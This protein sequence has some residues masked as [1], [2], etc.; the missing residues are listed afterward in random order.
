MKH[1]KTYESHTA[2][3]P[4]LAFSK[5]DSVETQTEHYVNDATYSDLDDD[6]VETPIDTELAILH[7]QEFIDDI[8]DY[9]NADS[10]YNIDINLQDFREIYNEM[11]VKA[12]KAIFD[13]TGYDYDKN[14]NEVF[15]YIKNIGNYNL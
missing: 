15:N 10:W 4:L 11:I 8:Y 5:D 6:G 12:K 14:Y 13:F 2:G 7:Q 9:L 1:L 3:G